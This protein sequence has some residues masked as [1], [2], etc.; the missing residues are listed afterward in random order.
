M[1]LSLPKSQV[2]CWGIVSLLPSRITMQATSKEWRCQGCRVFFKD[3]HHDATASPE[4]IPSCPGLIGIS[5]PGQ[6]CLLPT[7]DLYRAD[8]QIKLQQTAFGSWASFFKA[9]WSIPTLQCKLH[10]GYSLTR[11]IYT[12]PWSWEEEARRHARQFFLQELC[13]KENP[14]FPGVN[15]ALGTDANQHLRQRAKLFCCSCNSLSL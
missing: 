15:F 11:F 6:V 8:N 7:A 13:K 9:Y 10:C 12:Y 14:Y 2:L 1:Q 4:S 5:A 3:K